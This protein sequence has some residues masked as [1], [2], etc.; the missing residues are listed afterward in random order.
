MY[1]FIISFFSCMV[2]AQ[3]SDNVVT[4]DFPIRYGTPEWEKLN[5]Y[6][7]QLSPI[8]GLSMSL[9]NRDREFPRNDVQLLSFKRYFITDNIEVLDRVVESVNKLR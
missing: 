2:S 5:G 1:K 9:I 6:E 4:W 8:A 3:V 7:A